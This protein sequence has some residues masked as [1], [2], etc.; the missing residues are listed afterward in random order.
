MG[1]WETNFFW[2]I[3]GSRFFLDLRWRSEVNRSSPRFVIS[4]DAVELYRILENLACRI[5]LHIDLPISRLR[6]LAWFHS[7]G[8]RGTHGWLLLPWR[9]SR[10]GD[11][12]PAGSRWFAILEIF[13][14]SFVP[15]K[16]FYSKIK[17]NIF[18]KVGKFLKIFLG[19]FLE[20][21]VLLLKIQKNPKISKFSKFSKSWFS[22]GYLAVV[23]STRKS[24]V[25][26]LRVGS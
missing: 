20:K 6:F 15:G 26:G 3:L 12:G 24:R 7:G 8:V 23:V 4:E 25:S 16:I 11:W 2:W 1:K 13:R 10:S 17:K 19:F 14:N 9:A 5:N 21:N 18:E 22:R